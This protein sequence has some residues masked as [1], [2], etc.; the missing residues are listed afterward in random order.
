MRP[1]LKNTKNELLKAA[2]KYSTQHNFSVIPANKNKKSLI[3]WEEFQQ[4]RATEEEIIDWWKSYPNANVAIVTGSISKSLGVIDKDTEEEKEALEELFPESFITPMAE[5][6]RKGTHFYCLIPEGIEL[7]NNS[8]IIP[9]CDFRGEGGYILAPPSIN[10]QGKKYQWL[11]GLSIDQVPIAPLPKA[12]IDFVTSKACQASSFNSIN[13]FGIK[14]GCKENVRTWFTEGRRDNDLFHI[15]NSLIKGGMPEHEIVKVLEI[16]ANNCIPPFPE[17]ELKSKIES[18]L[19]RAERRERNLSREVQEWINLTN[20]YFF[21]TDA[22]E[23]LR[24]LTPEQKNNVYQIFHRLQKEGIIEKYGNKNGCYR[25]IDTS[26]EEINY[27]NAPDECIDIKWP[28][29]IENYVKTLPKNIIIIAGV[30]NSGK[31]AL[32]L[33]FIE[34]NMDKQEI[35]YFSSEMGNVELKDRL[36]KFQRQLYSWNFKAIERASNFSDVIRKDAVNVIDYLEIHDE[37]YKIGGLIKDIYD[38]L[39]KGIA[40]IAIQKNP[41]ALYG[42]GGARGLEKARLYLTIDSHRLKIEKAKNWMDHRINPNGLILEFKLHRGCE[43]E[44]IKDWHI[45]TKND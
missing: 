31:T 33:N 7:R 40:I 2:L 26:A 35:F 23:S 24:I 39:G 14:K 9:G 15:A 34:M 41:G 1:Q 8:R 36:N 3:K 44:L 4:R 10:E 29:S 5:T 11:D 13:A 21:L 19:K 18:A 30:S 20:G 45:N 28:F 22:Y 17:K 42:L 6:P 12:Y 27:L 32:L 38:K 37:F 25:L 16:I 43:F